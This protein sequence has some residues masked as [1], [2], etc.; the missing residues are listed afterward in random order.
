MVEVCPVG[1]A[2]TGLTSLKPFGN[3]SVW[4]NDVVISPSVN[5]NRRSGLQT[6]HDRAQEKWRVG[7]GGGGNY[8][9]PSLFA[10]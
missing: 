8:N 7:L 1:S 9:A 10:V 4:N 2:V 3:R 6:K 5:L